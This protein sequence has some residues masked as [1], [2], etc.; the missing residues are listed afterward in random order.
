MAVVTA[1]AAW[2]AEVMGTAA[3]AGSG[4]GRVPATRPPLEPCLGM[5]RGGLGV[6]WPRG[7]GRGKGGDG[8]E[9]AEG[10]L[11][12]Q[13]QGKGG[14][15]EEEE[16]EDVEWEVEELSEK[17]KKEKEEEE[18]E[19]RVRGFKLGEEERGIL[20][21]VLTGA[22]K[23]GE[24]MCT[25][26][27]K[28]DER[29]EFCG[30]GEVETT[31]HIF[32]ECERWEEARRKWFKVEE[33]KEILKMPKCTWLC[34]TLPRSEE[35]DRELMKVRVREGEEEW[36]PGRTEGEVKGELYEGGY[37]V[38]A[39]D[40]ACPEQQ[41]DSR[42]RR[43]AQALYYGEGHACNC[44][45]ETHT[46]GQGAQRAEVRAAVRW[47]AWAWGPTELWTD[48]ALVEGSQAGPGGRGARDD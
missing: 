13:G 40:G 15:G 32:W 37:L 47:V 6:A 10:I 41:G 28:G 44:A 11:P 27:L 45:W 21:T 23:T 2:T 18:E 48:S 1:V 30:N 22:V 4:M 43:S 36:P 42:L 5:L 7:A 16:E 29:C 3:G 20:R 17:E 26:G 38:V 14:K 46:L 19:D 35:P 31:G 25:A 9:R 12:A 8:G 33:R 39:S 24:R 34:G